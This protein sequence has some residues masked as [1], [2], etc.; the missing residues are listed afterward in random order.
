[1]HASGAIVSAAP[2]FDVSRRRLGR[3]P[4][5]NLRSPTTTT[6]HF[7]NASG[8]TRREEGVPPSTSA[9]RR[10]ATR[11]ADD[12]ADYYSDADDALSPARAGADPRRQ[13]RPR[14]SATTRQ[15]N[16]NAQN[17]AR[18]AGALIEG[19]EVFCLLAAGGLQG[20]QLY[21]RQKQQEREYQA[22]LAQEQRQQQE[23]QQ[24]Q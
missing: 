12:D 22:H 18:M 3:R 19:V 2:R 20:A 23:Y 6:P 9:S 24:R 8:I 4:G 21:E 10:D 13:P 16:N 1:M 15:S 5:S 17:N 11:A 14:P 7:G